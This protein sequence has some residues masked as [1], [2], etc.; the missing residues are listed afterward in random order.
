MRPSGGVQPSAFDQDKL[1]SH[2]AA[3][4][5]VCQKLPSGFLNVWPTTG[6]FLPDNFRIGLVE[7][8]HLTRCHNRLVMTPA[9]EAPG[10]GGIIQDRSPS[11][12]A[13]AH[14]MDE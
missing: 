10:R 12:P 1:F 5:R 13:A 4:L 8:S 2:F 14:A 3:N 11:A 6:T 9:S 7:S